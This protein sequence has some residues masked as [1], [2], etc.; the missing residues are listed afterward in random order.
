MVE[1]V[2]WDHVMGV[3]FSP[4][5]PYNVGVCRMA[6]QELCT[7]ARVVQGNGLQ[8]RKTVSSNLTQYSSLLLL[9]RFSVIVRYCRLSMWCKPPLLIGTI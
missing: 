8:T 7:D 1:F 2:V 9:R 3:R 4:P 6:A 5:R